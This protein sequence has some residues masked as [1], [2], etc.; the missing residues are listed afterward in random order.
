MPYQGYKK[1]AKDTIKIKRN[2]SSEP[3][4]IKWL[5]TA[6][7]KDDYQLVYKFNNWFFVKGKMLIA[8]MAPP[9][10]EEFY[11]IEFKAFLRHC[12]NI[13][14]L[15]KSKRV[16]RKKKPKSLEKEVQFF[17]A[18][19]YAKEKRD[20]KFENPHR[21]EDDYIDEHVYNQL[22]YEL[23]RRRCTTF[24]DIDDYNP[25]DELDWYAVSRKRVFDEEGL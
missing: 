14:S 2:K 24:A 1:W 21:D 8:Y 13:R 18:Y 16:K 25:D 19:Y 15:L 11:L 20:E 3:R 23:E 7:L 22:M 4:I 6:N 10:R 5:K 17:T 12:K 9:E